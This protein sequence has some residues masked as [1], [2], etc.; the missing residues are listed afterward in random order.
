MEQFP[1]IDMY[2]DTF[3][4]CR[5]EVC[6][7]VRYFVHYAQK[8]KKKSQELLKFIIIR[9]NDIY[10]LIRRKPATKHTWVCL[11]ATFSSY[12]YPVT[13]GTVWSIKSGTLCFCK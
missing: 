11:Y 13:P 3:R 7:H 1:E 12:F 10:L 6:S 9:Y 4:S 5:I 8:R 2:F